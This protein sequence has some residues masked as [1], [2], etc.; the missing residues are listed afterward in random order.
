[1]IAQ[2][3]AVMAEI[4]LSKKKGYRRAERLLSLEKET[5]ALFKTSNQISR[6]IVQAE[7]AN[8]EQRWLKDYLSP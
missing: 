6:D 3:K 8:E 2:N 5:K 7:G 1:M 4:D